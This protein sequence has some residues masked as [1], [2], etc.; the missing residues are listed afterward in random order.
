MCSGGEARVGRSETTHATA[1][2]PPRR[3]QRGPAALMAAATAGV[4]RD[5]RGWPP[6]TKTTTKWR[7]MLLMWFQRGSIDACCVHSEGHRG[8][9]LKPRVVATAAS[10]RPNWQSVNDRGKRSPNK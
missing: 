9:R 2:G 5:L 7:L 3:L 8:A 6:G 10:Q 4:R 1:A